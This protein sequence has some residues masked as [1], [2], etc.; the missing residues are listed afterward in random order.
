MQYGGLPALTESPHHHSTTNTVQQKVNAVYLLSKITGLL[1]QSSFRYK[2]NLPFKFCHIDTP[3]TPL[4]IYL[5][6][7]THITHKYSQHIPHR[8]TSHIPTHTTHTTY[9]HIYANKHTHAILTH[10]H[11]NKKHMLTP[12]WFRKKYVHLFIPAWLGR[13]ESGNSPNA[14]HL[15]GREIK[16]IIS[17]Q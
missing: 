13:A 10:M 14:H 6:H 11:S 9:P 3:H 4:H 15:M 8:H 5:P 1:L 12:A 2:K 16:Y 7:T 17:M